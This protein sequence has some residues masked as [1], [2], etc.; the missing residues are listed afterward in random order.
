MVARQ[1]EL[2]LETVAAP[3][4]A[5]KRSLAGVRSPGADIRWHV[6]VEGARGT[7][8]AACGTCALERVT[9]PVLASAV[10]F[11]NRCQKPGCRQ[12]WG[13]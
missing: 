12:R 11:T 5:G 1:R 3:V 6:A 13:K 8:V 9:V 4:Y 2:P 10:P 7:I